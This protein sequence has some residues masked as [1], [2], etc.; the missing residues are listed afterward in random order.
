MVRKTN[1]TIKA[2]STKAKSG[3]KAKTDAKTVNEASDIYSLDNAIFDEE[4]ANAIK[5]KKG[6]EE[7]DKGL[8]NRELPSRPDYVQIALDAQTYR[9]ILLLAK[10]LKI[11]KEEAAKLLGVKKAHIPFLHM[12][13]NMEEALVK[14]SYYM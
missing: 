13:K 12:N 5:T 6:R 10:K 4:L 14:A 9:Y 11:E 3:S 1:D 2:E 7:Y 8:K